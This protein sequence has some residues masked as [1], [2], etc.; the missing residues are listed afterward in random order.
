MEYAREFIGPWAGYVSRWMYW[1]NW[2]A[3]GVAEIT[4]VGI[5]VRFLGARRPTV[6]QRARRP[7]A[8]HPHLVSVRLLGELEFWF[9]TLKVVAIVAFLLIGAFLVATGP[10]VGAAQG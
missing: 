8:A 6:G 7:A 9:A 10:A 5:Y 3:T 1:P 2:A 4:A